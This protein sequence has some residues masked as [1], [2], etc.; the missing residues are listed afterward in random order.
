MENLKVLL[1][2][3]SEQYNNPSFI[4]TDPISIP[5][6]FTKKE[7][8]EISGFLTALISWG[9]R[10]MI[11]KSA[12]KLME[13]MNRS[14]YDFLMQAGLD[15]L[16]KLSGFVYRTFNSDDLLFL[17]TALRNVYLHNGGLEIVAGNG[18]RESGKI[19]GAIMSMRNVLLETAHLK[20]SEKHLA[21][22]N[23]G[24]AA[25]RINM[26]LRWMVRSD[27]KGVDFG[28]WNEIPQNKLMCPLD[29]HSGR[30]ARKLGLLSRKQNDW[31]A[32]E[33]LTEN[34][35]AFDP[36]DPVKYDFALFGMGVF[37]RF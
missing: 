18:Y 35:R 22:P 30:V 37:E 5:H 33:E 25:K 15:E 26:F 2:R 34:L 36:E 31:K 6:Q 11:I 29:I 16:Q 24:S 21:N 9:R 4:P 10:E 20:R 17:L 28:F 32:V 27:D 13:R 12:D 8:I 1:D 3:K 7:D 14:P 23:T 19:K